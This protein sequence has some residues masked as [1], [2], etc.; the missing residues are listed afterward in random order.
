MKK[1]TVLIIG[2][3]GGIGSGIAKYL[4]NKGYIVH[5]TYNNK[6][7]EYTQYYLN[8]CEEINDQLS[9]IP[10]CECVIFAAGLNAFCE[11]SKLNIDEFNRVMKVTNFG[12]LAI[13]NKFVR[14]DKTLKKIIFITSNAG[15]NLENKTG[16]YSFS[17]AIVIDMVKILSN[18]LMNR[19]ITV[20]AIAPGWCN[21][22]MAEN[23]LKYNNTSIYNEMK[24][25][26][27]GVFVSP[28]EIGRICEFL[29]LDKQSHIT[30]QII[31]INS[32]DD[33]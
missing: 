19:K 26:R 1:E 22:K 4:S 29:L 2:G 3:S 7:E 25:K 32:P 12:P 23:V 9:N 16:L 6:K 33:I 17:K 24:K 5:S 10:S 15:I 31:E 27:D 20:N 8:L 14:E 30:G 21:T 18:E 28:E 13:I 11:L